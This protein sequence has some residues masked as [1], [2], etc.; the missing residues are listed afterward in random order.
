LIWVSVVINETVFG[1]SCNCPK[2][3]FDEWLQDFG[4]FPN[5]EGQQKI[6]QQ[7]DDDLQ[8]FQNVDVAKS[9]E[10][11]KETFRPGSSSFCHYAISKNGS[12][13]P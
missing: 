8:S 10:E 6:Y 4:C 7:I 12:K 5:E 11:A 1:E 2:E 9:Y 3:D 13:T